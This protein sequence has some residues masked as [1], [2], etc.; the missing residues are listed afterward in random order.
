MM[1]TKTPQGKPLILDLEPDI[2]I[3]SKLNA[4][5]VLHEFLH[6]CELQKKPHVTVDAGF[7]GSRLRTAY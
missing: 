1:A 7:S 4:R 2:N 5:Q 3:A 6:R